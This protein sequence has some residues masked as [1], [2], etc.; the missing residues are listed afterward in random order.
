[1]SNNS[2]SITLVRGLGLIAAISIVVGNVIGTG[3]FLKARVMTCN[4][5]TP[6][7]VLTVWVVAGLLSLAGALTYAELAAM[8]PHAGGEYVFLRES[9]GS[10]LAF[11][12][13]WMQIFIAKTGSQASVAVAFAIFLNVLTGGAL[14]RE[15]FAL[16]LFGWRL[17]F[18]RVQIVAL[19]IIAL[20]TAVNCAAVVVSGW[21]ATF[22]TVIK[23]ALVLGVGLGAFLFAPGDF[24]HFGMSNA[25]G[26]CDGVEPAARAGLAGFSA[27]MLGALWGYDGWNNVTL[28]AGEVKNPQRDIP[29]ALIGGTSLIILL[30]VFVNAA[31]FYALTPTEVAS[32]SPNSSVATEVTSRFLGSLA[33]GLIAAALMASSIGTLHTSI[34][35]GARVPFAMARDGLFL[36]SLAKLSARSRVPIGALIAQA[37]WAGL[38]ALSGSFDTLTDYVIFGSWIF[39]G[40]TTSAVFVLRRRRPDVPR[41]YRAWGYPVVP[42]LFL[43]VTAWLLVMTLKTAP[44]RS[45][46]GLGLIALGLPVYW[47]ITRRHAA[48]EPEKIFA[49][50]K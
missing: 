31:Y 10:R 4:V 1:M 15:I 18:G 17:P 32:V 27:A 30:Y 13:G 33:T 49:D 5:E 48:R 14:D 20:L 37:I 42:A 8:M 22:L 21:V 41:P 35:T 19:G 43:V 38:L 26:T 2:T 16:D 6:G 47:Y 44:L 40:L 9:Y 11:L 28:V 25:G 39:Y 23:I 24:A 3:V 45:F 50:P 12:Y 46:I 29:L 36:Q 34:L 7:M